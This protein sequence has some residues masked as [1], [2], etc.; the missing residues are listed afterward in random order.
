MRYS[1]EVD[2]KLRKRPSFTLERMRT[3]ITYPWSGIRVVPRANDDHML[4]HPEPDP[5]Q[6]YAGITNF[7][8]V[9]VIPSLG[10]NGDK[11]MHDLVFALSEPKSRTRR[12][13]ADIHPVH[14]ARHAVD[15]R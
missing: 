9:D 4:Y 7:V 6:G 3:R 13:D 14:F 1:V 2:P 11:N 10:L 12:D 8:Y 15:N 5:C